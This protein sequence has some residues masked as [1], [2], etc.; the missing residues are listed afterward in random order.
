M[1][2]RA[3]KG[4]DTG[5][6]V[7]IIAAVLA[8]G[9][10]GY[11]ALHRGKD[12]MAGTTPLNVRDYMENA[13]SLS[14]NVYSVTGKIEEKPHW[15]PDKGQLVVVSVEGDS[16]AELIPVLIPSEFNGE[17]VSRGDQFTLKVE[18]GAKGRLIARALS[19][20]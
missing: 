12:P 6:L 11:F 16:G 20:S 10:F 7:G 9:G 2:R 15:T 1:A 8:V 19:K 3:R 17:N 14:G 4:I 18:V 5:V 13:N